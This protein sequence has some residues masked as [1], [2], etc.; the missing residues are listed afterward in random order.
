MCVCACKERAGLFHQTRKV[1]LG[2]IESDS[3]LAEV[4]LLPLSAPGPTSSKTDHIFPADTGTWIQVYD[5][6]M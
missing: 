3:L 6:Y 5:T 2:A 1:L 4:R